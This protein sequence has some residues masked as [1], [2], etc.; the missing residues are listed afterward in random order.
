MNPSPEHTPSPVAEPVSAFVDTATATALG[1]WPGTDPVEAAKVSLGIF[2]S[3]NLPF[4]PQLPS[5][6]VGSDSIGR[7]AA[8]LTELPVDVQPYGWRFV[9]RPGLDFLRAESALSTDINV[10]ADVVGAGELS[11]S[12][13][14]V[15]SVGP[16][17]LAASIHLHYGERAVRDH[18]A[19]RDIAQSLAAGLHAHA[20]KVQSAIPGAALTLQIDEPHIAA[21]LA[22]SIPTS[23]GYRTLRAIPR[24]ELRHIWSDLVAAAR[25]AGFSQV[26]LN[27]APAEKALAEK[28]SAEGMPGDNGN[29]THAA[30]ATSWRQ[31]LE[32][33]LESGVDAVAVPLNMLD[34]GHWETLA[35]ALESGMGVWAGTVPASSGQVPASYSA[36]VERIMRPWRKLGLAESG[37][38]QLRITEES[39]LAQLTPREAR[40]VLS[41]SLDVAQALGDIRNA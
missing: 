1:S 18:G 23:S 37:L 6:G 4:L 28:A 9:D 3:P 34:G 25:D 38:N 8:L 20:L 31:A 17:S 35:G 21:V 32:I 36:L 16:F 40:A 33:A 12:A 14:K 24:S 41:R 11:P 39:G 13:F 5:R 7:T 10:L 29:S 27:L 19:R 2:P 22:G 26:A 30:E 15:Q